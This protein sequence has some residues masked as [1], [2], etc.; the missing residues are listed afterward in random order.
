MGSFIFRCNSVTF[1]E[2][3]EK[4]LFGDVE[5]YLPLMKDLKIGSNVFLYNT[6]NW[7]LYG[8]F[9]TQSRAGKYLNSRAWGGKF[10][11]QVKVKALK[12]TKSIPIEKLKSIIRFKGI[13][14]DPALSEEQTTKILEVFSKAN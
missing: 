2:C 4:N 5:D 7:Q 11:A 9:I 1:K 10:P 14:P 8:V 6:S 3:L 13:Y 12:L